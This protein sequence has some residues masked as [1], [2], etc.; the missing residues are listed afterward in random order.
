MGLLV[1][2]GKSIRARRDVAA[3]FGAAV[4]LVVLGGVVFRLWA[5]DSGPRQA[6]WPR[7]TLAGRL[8]T[9]M[10][11]WEWT[12]RELPVDPKI[13]EMTDTDDHVDR[14]YRNGTQ[15]VHLWIAFGTRTR[16]LM[17]HRP[18]VCLRGMGYTLK[19]TLTAAVPLTDGSSL[20]SRFCRFYG[21]K[22]D[23]TECTKLYYYI[24]DGE[25]CADVSTMR[26]KL[27]G[28]AGYVAKVEITALQE[29]RL[30]EKAG[31]AA[32]RG[33]AAVSAQTIQKALVGLW[34]DT[35]RPGAELQTAGTAGPAGDRG[36]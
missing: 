30:D 28:R 9:H 22:E 29:G 15:A 17:P 7:G 6:P 3:A 25:W 2:V 21:G 35:H 26:W 19:P 13:L 12:G 23:A 18:E 16:D 33:F 1:S 24:A 27:G 10:G 36:R 20:P 5:G 8:A 14:I 4:V 34:R 31:D 11:G 32:V